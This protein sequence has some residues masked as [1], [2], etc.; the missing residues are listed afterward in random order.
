MNQLLAMRVFARVVESGSFSRT[1]D[2]LELPRSTISKLI[3]D[4]EA[5]LQI[6]LLCRTTRKVVAT[7]EGLAYY[8]QAVRL[9]DELDLIDNNARGTRQNLQ[10][11]LR[12]DAPSTFGTHLLIPALVDFQKLYPEITVALGISDRAVDLVAEGVDCVVRAGRLD[13]QAMVGRHLIELD[14][15]T[16]AAPSY[17]Q[18]YGIPSH[19]REL[20]SQYRRLGYFVAA[21]DRRFSQTWEKGTERFEMSNASYSTNDGNGLLAMMLAGLG[22]G[23]HFSHCLQP[24]IDRGELVAVLT[25]WI[26]PRMPFHVLYP[27][28][29]HQSIRLKVFIEW[30]LATFRQ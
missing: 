29:P 21:T 15:I 18:R 1:A 11:H 13:E 10:G 2:Q 19:P 9:I 12:I 30:L 14:Y 22:A 17:I 23:Q 8:Q 7:A 27:P 4:L 6:K 3:A 28:N 20:E 5:H 16:C 26:Q 25:D 24:H